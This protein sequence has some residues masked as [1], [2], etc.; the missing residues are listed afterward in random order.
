[1]KTGHRAT[2]EKEVYTG[3]GRD[4]YTHHIGGIMYMISK[5]LHFGCVY[6]ASLYFAL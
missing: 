5:F 1:M 3:V 6:E 2:L 4:V